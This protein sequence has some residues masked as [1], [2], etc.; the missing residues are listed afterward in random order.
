MLISAHLSSK[1]EK[2]EKQVTAF[3]KD[4]HEFKTAHPELHVLV[5]ID[6]NSF[7]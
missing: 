2:N 1:K 4:L 5:G 7:I 3:M 6:A